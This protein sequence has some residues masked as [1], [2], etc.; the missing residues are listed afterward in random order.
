MLAQGGMPMD[1]RELTLLVTGAANALYEALPAGDLAVLGAPGQSG[2]T[3]CGAPF[4][5]GAGQ[6]GPDSR[7]DGVFPEIVWTGPDCGAF[8]IYLAWECSCSESEGLGRY[9][10]DITILSHICPKS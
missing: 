10:P 5:Q 4:L 9:L 8:Q 2:G 7:R 6:A 1:P 3:D